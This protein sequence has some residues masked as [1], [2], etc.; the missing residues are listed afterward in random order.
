[1]LTL[2][3]SEISVFKRSKANVYISDQDKYI[4][5]YEPVMFGDIT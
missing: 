3:K 1:M 5:F 2:I 4:K